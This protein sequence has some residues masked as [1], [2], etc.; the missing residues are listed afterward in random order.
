MSEVQ[1]PPEVSGEGSPAPAAVKAEGSPDKIGSEL[2]AARAQIA[3]LERKLAAATRKGKSAEE[4]EAALSE[5]EEKL[6]EIQRAADAALKQRDKLLQDVLR[7][8]LEA[9]P[10][11]TRELVRRAGGGGPEA[12][13]EALEL[14]EK[15]ASRERKSPQ[16]GLLPNAPQAQAMADYNRRWDKVLKQ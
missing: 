11:Q 4:L 6:G 9:L 2:D 5:R 13:I 15:A 1:K 7:P 3:A 16:G 8:R 10:E 14:A 12:L